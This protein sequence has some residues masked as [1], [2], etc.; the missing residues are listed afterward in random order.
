MERSQ[1]GRR[2]GPGIFLR[3]NLLYSCFGLR[4]LSI[5]L[6]AW[7]KPRGR[8]QEHPYRTYCLPA[9]PGSEMTRSFGSGENARGRSVMSGEIRPGYLAVPFHMMAWRLG[10]PVLV[11]S[12]RLHPSPRLGCMLVGVSGP[13]KLDGAPVL[14]FSAFTSQASA[15]MHLPATIGESAFPA[16]PT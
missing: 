10:C 8:R 2:D 15:T 4:Q 13:G 1:V 5:V 16:V 14:C 6:W 9:K 3:H 7:V 11:Q 12:G